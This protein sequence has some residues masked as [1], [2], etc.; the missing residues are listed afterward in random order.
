[1]FKKIFS[2]VLVLALALSLGAGLIS[3]SGQD[4][5]YS[6]TPVAKDEIK[7]GLIT[8]HDKN[9]TYDKNFLDAMDA[10]IANLGLREDQLI[11]KVGIDLDKVSMKIYGHTIEVKMPR[12]KA[13]SYEID[14]EQFINSVTYESK[15][16]I[17]KNLIEI[18][19]LQR[20]F[21]P[22]A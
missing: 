22:M 7:V 16:G 3:C 5:D 4:G 9:S 19:E 18:E 17:N 20:L 1:M 11:V 8:L 21:V 12:V 10:A 14:E 2:L 13:L 6:L 15:D